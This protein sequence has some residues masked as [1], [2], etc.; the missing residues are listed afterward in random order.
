M[1][2]PLADEEMELSVRALPRA[3]AIQW[4][5]EPS[6]HWFSVCSPWT[7]FSCAL[8]QS[9]PLSQGDLGLVSSVAPSAPTALLL[10]CIQPQQPSFRSL[11]APTLGFASGVCGTISAAWQAAPQVPPP[12]LASSGLHPSSERPSWVPVSKNV[13]PE[14]LFPVTLFVSFMVLSQKTQSEG[15]EREGLEPDTSMF[16]VRDPPF[17]GLCDLG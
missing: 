13:S 9:L 14:L 5:S 8:N 7:G 10:L 1:Q 11:I 15:V 17:L 2:G 6:L 12:F 16:V 3:P 4:E